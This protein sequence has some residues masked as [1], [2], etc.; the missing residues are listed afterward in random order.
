MT[1]AEL[2]GATLRETGHETDVVSIESATKDMVASHDCIVI[3]SPSW[4]DEG[5]DGQPLPEI[6]IFLST[7]TAADLAGKKMAIVGLGDTAYPHFCGAVDVLEARLKELGVA[8]LATPS[9][10]IDRYYSLRD[11][12]Q[13]VKDWATA[14]ANTLTS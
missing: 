9:L 14:L 11:N 5:K 12:E 4:E 10:K 13:K 8:T 3:A 6:R 7:L 1:A 2:V